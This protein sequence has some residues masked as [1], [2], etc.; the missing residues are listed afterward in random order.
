MKQFHR[1]S[2]NCFQDIVAMIL[3][4]RGYNP[5]MMYQGSLNFGYNERETILGNRI[6]P[7]RDGDWLDNQLFESIN[8][9]YGLNVIQKY[10]SISAIR[11][12]IECNEGIILEVDVFDCSWHMLSGRYH[13]PHY[14]WVIDYNNKELKCV[15]PYGKPFVYYQIDKLVSSEK[16]KYYQYTFTER[17]VLKTIDDMI[18]TALDNCNRGYRGITDIEQMNEM[19]KCIKEN[20]I[21]LVEECGGLK[22]V[23]A[24]PIIRAFEWILWSRVN[25][26]DLVKY[27]DCESKTCTLVSLLQD[28]VYCW[29]RVKNYIMRD[30]IR[31][32][33]FV[34]E[35]I[36][37]YVNLSIQA[38]QAIMNE[39]HKMRNRV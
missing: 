6:T 10:G 30:I 1:E 3:V 33:D 39:M 32:K 24:V 29:D 16:I 14:C 11:K 4:N 9:S 21:N 5:L 23:Y 8:S 37:E 34:D 17:P 13:Q 35:G 12:C 28:A 22:D 2:N 27:M 19:L 7:S 26:E 25:F 18:N 36:V 31:H 15:L 20:G 38:E